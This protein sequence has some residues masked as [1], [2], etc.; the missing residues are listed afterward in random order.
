MK[1]SCRSIAAFF[2]TTKSSSW[3]FNCIKTLAINQV[4]ASL[5]ARN[6]LNFSSYSINYWGKT[7]LNEWG[8]KQT[9]KRKVFTINQIFNLVESFYSFS[10]VNFSFQHMLLKQKT[11]IALNSFIWENL[12]KI[13][14]EWLRS[15]Q[16][17]CKY[18]KILMNFNCLSTNKSN[19]N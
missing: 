10:S 17:S 4:I 1:E 13:S 15:S 9:K 2:K 12:I 8:I 6:Y 19:I 5:N 14:V 7:E 11:R 16:I 18:S 3:L